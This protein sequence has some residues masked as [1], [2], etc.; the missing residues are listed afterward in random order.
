MYN[1]AK[2]RGWLV[3]RGSGYRRERKASPLANIYRQY[4][5]A[6]NIPCVVISNTP[7]ATTT[8][9]AMIDI[10]TLRVAAAVE[11][12]FAQEILHTCT[13]GIENTCTVTATEG[14]QWSPFMVILP[15]EEENGGGDS[16]RTTAPIWQIK[17]RMVCFDCTDSTVAKQV[18]KKG[19]EVLFDRCLSSA[20]EHV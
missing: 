16:H 14:L 7:T 6:M 11:D 15:V 18:V 2:K 5:D 13:T 9:T 1:I 3:L 12:R 17:P 10:S 20:A 19:T 8:T 4:C